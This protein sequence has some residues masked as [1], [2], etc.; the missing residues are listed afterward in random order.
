MID[1]IIRII[2]VTIAVAAVWWAFTHI[3]RLIQKIHE[4]L[5]YL[6]GYYECRSDYHVTS[7]TKNPKNNI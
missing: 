5:A 6:H 7:T 3:F 1:E 2:Q 4:Y